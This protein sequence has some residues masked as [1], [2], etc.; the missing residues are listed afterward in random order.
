MWE[1]GG[2]GPRILNIDTKWRWSASRTFRFISRERT[3]SAHWIRVWVGPR[4]CLGSV[5][6]RRNTFFTVAGNLTLVVQPLSQLI[7]WLR[8]PCKFRKLNNWCV[9]DAVLMG[10]G[11]IPNMIRM[12]LHDIWSVVSTLRWVLHI[13]WDYLTYSHLQVIGCHYTDT[14]FILLCSSHKVLDLIPAVASNLKYISF[15]VIA[16]KANSRNVMYVN[17]MN[18]I[19]KRGGGYYESETRFVYS[20]FSN[21]LFA[22]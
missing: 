2:I 14:F 19:C 17:Y 3:P 1:S 5:A 10:S 22:T 7:Y 15:M 18:N 21:A 16:W 13:A 9:H 12:H 6:G 20:V 4:A 11:S 8:Y